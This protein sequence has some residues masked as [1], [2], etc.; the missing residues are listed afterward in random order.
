[1]FS[2]STPIKVK[3]SQS[4]KEIIRLENCKPLLLLLLERVSTARGRVLAGTEKKQSVHFDI[5]SMKP[6]RSR[7]QAAH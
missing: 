1:M 2:R 4:S 6:T 5:L 7:I 3:K